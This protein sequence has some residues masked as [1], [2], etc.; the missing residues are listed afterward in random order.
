MS[1]PQ[2]E[3][4]V[5]ITDFSPSTRYSVSVTAV[6]G[7]L[8]SRALQATYKGERGDSTEPQRQTDGA[9][10]PDEANEIFGGKKS[11]TNPPHS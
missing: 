3:H 8:L 6:R 2:S 11:S 9:Q 7:G 4:R 1:V 5:L 10:P